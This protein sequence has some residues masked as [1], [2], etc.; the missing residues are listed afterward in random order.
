MTIAVLL[1]FRRNPDAAP[2]AP[3]AL[4]PPVEPQ[5]PANNLYVTP[6]VTSTVATAAPPAAAVAGSLNAPPPPPPHALTSIDAGVSNVI[7]CTTPVVDGAEN[8]IGD[9]GVNVPG[10][11]GID[12][13]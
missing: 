11:P 9:A 13:V 12:V 1:E 10:V 8:D 2:P 7:V 5:P 3:P 4:L 6:L